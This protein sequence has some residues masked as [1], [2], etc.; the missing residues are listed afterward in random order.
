MRRLLQPRLLLGLLLVAGVAIYGLLFAGRD[1]LAC[2]AEE[3]GCGW[4]LTLV[5]SALG[6][7]PMPRS[8]A[9]DAEGNIYLAGESY[10]DAADYTRNEVLLA[11]YDASGAPIWVRQLRAPGADGF[12]IAYGIALDDAGNFCIGGITDG[13]YDD[14]TQP[15]GRKGF[16]SRYDAHGRQ[17]WAVDRSREVLA[18]AHDRAGNCY[19]SSNLG[20]TKLTAQG[21]V[22][23]SH[24]QPTSGIVLTSDGTP[25]II[26]P[27]AEA[28][29]PRLVRLDSAGRIVRDMTLQLGRESGW[30]GLQFSR[31][32][33]KAD[34]R[35]HLYLHANI[36][37][38]DRKGNI[39]IA[40][41]L[42]KLTYEG[43]LLW[44]RHY[45]VEGERWDT[46][47]HVLDNKGILMSGMYQRIS[48]P[49][50]LNSF[51]MRYDTTGNLQWVRQHSASEDNG[52]GSIGVDSHGNYYIAGGTRGVLDGQPLARERSNTPFIA[53]N[54]P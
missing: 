17:L 40:A 28:T 27:G 21:M 10:P 19:A 23:W 53:R 35:G 50:P 5:D 11:K 32:A 45:G 49:C 16:V 52:A 41:Y 22:A 44:E 26:G 47:D 3:S 36:S 7:W 20:V 12:N 1:G 6:Y 33:L 2:P 37:G 54:R 13:S 24:S 31:F 39:R 18:V 38:N 15:P 14:P 4:T 46:F 25:Y 9:V 42:A 30:S 29:R 34:G 48:C 8:M 51:V 43:E